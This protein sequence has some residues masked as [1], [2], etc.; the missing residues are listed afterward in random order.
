MEIHNVEYYPTHLEGDD[1]LNTFVLRMQ[2]NEATIQLQCKTSTHTKEDAQIAAEL[3]KDAKRQL[4]K[5]PEISSGEEKVFFDKELTALE[6]ELV[7]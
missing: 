6:D 5:L 4:A 2:T 1:T 3:L 7:A